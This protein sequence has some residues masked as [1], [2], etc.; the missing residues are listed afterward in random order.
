MNICVHVLVALIICTQ[1]ISSRC[2]GKFSRAD[3]V[4][5]QVPLARTSLSQ[6]I[7]VSIC[8]VVKLFVGDILHLIVV[9]STTGYFGG[10]KSQLFYL[11]AASSAISAA[12]SLS[13]SSHRAIYKAAFGTMLK[14]A[15]A[16]VSIFLFVIGPL[17]VPIVL[18]QTQVCQF[19]FQ[20]SDLNP[21]VLQN[22]V[23]N[24][25]GGAAFSGT[26]TITDAMTSTLGTD[27][28]FP[29]TYIEDVEMMNTMTVQSVSF[30][31]SVGTA[32]IQNNQA[33]TSITFSTYPDPGAIYSSQIVIEGN[34]V[35]TSLDIGSYPLN[36]ATFQVTGNPLL[37]EITF[38][39][40][41]PPT[42]TCTPN[43]TT[44][45]VTNSA[46][47][48]SYNFLIQPSYP[49][50]PGRVWGITN[51]LW[52]CQNTMVIDFS[53]SC[54][55][56]PEIVV[57]N[58]PLALTQS[59]QLWDAGN[60]CLSNATTNPLYCSEIQVQIGRTGPNASMS[61]SCQGRSISIAVPD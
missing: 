8:V 56:Q 48:V 4:A 35:L 53:Q 27:L 18:S 10:V 32:H 55:G 37:P 25:P 36:A 52:T 12:V 47:G 60:T 30:P 57:D 5:A 50:S 58:S 26:L 23:S 42:S 1:L 15:V 46:Y 22:I 33:L 24:C 51:Q 41:P 6:N 13:A 9:T 44:Q 29:F 39:P 40:L 45:Q 31:F 2:R 7:V 34:P 43:A 38:Y 16:F 49:A 14:Q 17:I 61:F 19:P 28:S 59:L 20:E 11:T 54:T 21:S 3:V